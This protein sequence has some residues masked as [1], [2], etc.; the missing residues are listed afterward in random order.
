[1]ATEHSGSDLPIALRRTKRKAEVISPIKP[2]ASTVQQTSTPSRSRNSKKVRFSD[3]HQ[4][5]TALALPKDRTGLTPSVQR[6]GL[7]TPKSRRPATPARVVS[8]PV[9]SSPADVDFLQFTPLKQ[10]LGEREK[11]RIRRNHLSEEVNSYEADKRDNAVLRKQIVAKDAELHRLRQELED[12]KKL[13]AEQ[14]VSE[15]QLA[16]SQS[17][18]DEIEQELSALRQSFNTVTA[19]SHPADDWSHVPLITQDG[20]NSAGGDTIQIYEDEN[21]LQDGG[22][23]AAMAG[24]QDQAD[25]ALIGAEIESARQYKQDLLSSFSKA[26]SLDTDLNFAD[27]PARPQPKPSAPATPRALQH[28]MQKQLRAANAQVDEV[29]LAL[30]S[31]ENG[32]RALGF[33]GDASGSDCVKAVANHFRD[34]RL[35]LERLVPGETTISFQNRALLPEF[36]SKL[37]RLLA[38]L[39]DREAELQSLRTQERNLKGNF[40][41]TLIAYDRANK[42]VKELENT[43]D[44]LADEGMQTRMRAQSLERERDEKAADVQKLSAV[45]TKLDAEKSKMETLL[46]SVEDEHRSALADVQATSRNWED[47]AETAEAKVAAEST[48]RRKAEESAVARLVRI[49]ELESSM[50]TSK[51]NAE[52]VE[53]DLQALQRNRVSHTDGFN[54]RIT[55]LSTALT[56]ANAEI[57]KLQTLNTK[58]EQRY[59]KEIRA[60]GETVEMLQNVMFKAA[61]KV[62][63]KGKNF[64][65]SSRVRLANWEME[66]DP[67]DVEVGED[68]APM[69]PVSCCEVCES[70]G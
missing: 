29:Q 69:T 36:V 26:R 34:I 25:A 53:R 28:D 40:D 52:K 5:S 66:S 46:L 47:R 61:T 22:D 13:E 48:G 43:V 38:Q 23:E 4:R 31:L 11:R 67:V 58:L 56:S 19:Q 12:A 32:V 49:Q 6:A 70:G 45:L 2:T 44:Q 17:H 64:R 59:H 21:D 8:A 35:E 50:A 9:S 18:V 10:A 14:Q 30:S 33:A 62:I 20:P 51:T 41:H 15:E 68:G 55:S 57:T 60:A 24:A 16:T 39:G 65:R 37:K 63:D 54:A 7:L 27:S 1:M 3:L 42:K